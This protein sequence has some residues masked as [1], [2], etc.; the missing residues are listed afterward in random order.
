M[1]G[2][3]GYALLPSMRAWVPFAALLS[4]PLHTIIF[5]GSAEAAPSRH[6]IDAFVAGDVWPTPEGGGHGIVYLGWRWQAPFGLVYAQ[7]NTDTLTA[8]VTGLC[9][10]ND[11]CVGAQLKG[12][13]GFAGLLPDYYVDGQRI[14][15]LGFSASYL[16]AA[17]HAQYRTADRLFLTFQSRARRWFF[18]RTGSTRSDF[19]LP[20]DTWVFEQQLD[21]TWWSFAPD[22]ST[23]DPHRPSWRLTGLGFGLQA[24]FHHRLDAP[25]WGIADR[26]TPDR[27]LFFIRQWA[28]IGIPI[29]T[30]VRLQLTERGG[31]GW[32]EDDLTRARIG[33][34]NPYV[35]PIAGVPWAG[36]LA[37]RYL[38]G[39]ATLHFNVGGDIEVGPQFDVVTLRDIRRRDE[40]AFGWAMGVGAFVDVRWGR[41]QGELRAGYSPDAS[42]WQTNTPHLSVYGLLGRTIEL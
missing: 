7:Y 31:W 32:S 4:L 23:Q 24:N 27:N 3:R 21:L 5:S 34:L 12:Q 2:P 30:R 17:V 13:V 6:A 20:K 19:P 15:N 39:Q 26:N 42:G 18:A 1:T 10:T 16:S 14:L 40:D 35:V 41:W 28:A 38:A 9:L 33:G 36:F 25:S 22:P 8:G 11:L 37:G 29:G